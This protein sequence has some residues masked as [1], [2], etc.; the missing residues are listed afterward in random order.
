MSNWFGDIF[1]PIG[2]WNKDTPQQVADR[3]GLHGLSFGES[4]PGFTGRNRFDEKQEDLLGF[5]QGGGDAV[6]GG[7]DNAQG[8]Y[9]NAQGAYD[10]AQGAYDSGAKI[11]TRGLGAAQTNQFNA[12]RLSERA[13]RTGVSDANGIADTSQ[14]RAD[15]LAGFGTDAATGLRGVGDSGAAGI[16]QQA[17]Q[18]GPSLAQAQFDRGQ[19]QARDDAMSMAATMGRGGNQA[20]ANRQ[21]MQALAGQSA[22]NNANTAIMRAQEESALRNSRIGA[23][24]SAG[25]LQAGAYGQAGSLGNSA[26]S[27]AAGHSQAGLQGAGG[28]KQNALQGAAGI[29]TTL[30]GQNVN[31]ANIGANLQLGGLGA[32]NT[33]AGVQNSAAGTQGNLGNAMFSNANNTY[34][35]RATAQLNADMGFG[36]DAQKREAE[37]NATNAG[38]IGGLMNMV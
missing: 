3:R 38:F 9:D 20:L 18:R 6:M 34:T 15:A 11:A 14:A 24:T 8:A 17:M 1:D 36:T 19:L 4:S 22:T 28:L 31:E 26:L 25:Q 35:D 2:L 33:A 16:M 12:D 37:E 29:Q 13:V 7:I 27:G 32:Q 5:A 30:G 23:A 10:N 21:A